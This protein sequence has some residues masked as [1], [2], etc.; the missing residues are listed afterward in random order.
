MD[1]IIV[2][3]HTFIYGKLLYGNKVR[4]DFMELLG[5]GKKVQLLRYYTCRFIKG[6]DVSSYSA[7]DPDRYVLKKEYY[8]RRSNE[9][10]EL[11]KVNKKSILQLLEDKREYVQ[12]LIKKNKLKIG[13][14]DDLI[15]VFNHY[16]SLF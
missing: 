4:D 12:T 1:S 5:G 3:N 9:V 10:A 11:I 7:P 13:K 16:N 15:K 14:E 2:N 6:R 8:I